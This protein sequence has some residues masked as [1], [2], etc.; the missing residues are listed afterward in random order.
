MQGCQKGMMRE[1]LHS[2]SPH[3]V[4]HVFVWAFARKNEP[5][6]AAATSFTQ[7][8]DGC[9]RATARA[10]EEG[11]I[12]FRQLTLTR[13]G[14]HYDIMANIRSLHALAISSLI[15]M[16]AARIAPFHK[17]H[18]H[19]NHAAVMVGKRQEYV[20][21]MGP[22]PSIPA[23]TTSAPN[24]LNYITPSP[25]ASP[26]AVTAQS[27]IVTSYIPQYTLCELPPIEF[28]SISPVPSAV[29]TTAPYRNY[30]ISIPEGNG[31]C[32]TIY[33]P[34]ITMVCA[35]TL[36][37]LVERWT[38]SNC[39][40]DLTFST[41]YGYVLV[42]PKEAMPGVMGT[43]A[44]VVSVN[45]SFVGSHADPRPAYSVGNVTAS[46]NITAISNATASANATASSNATATTAL[47]PRQVSNATAT[48]TPG[49]SIETLTTYFLA[50]WQQLTAGTAPSEVDLKVCRTFPLND[51][52]ECIR[53]YQVWSTSL[54]T[55]STTTVTSIN[56]STT[57]HGM[58][59][60][61]VETF[62]ANVTELLTTFSM[63]TTMALE[64]QTEWTSTHTATRTGTESGLS[65][66]M[67]PT[68]YETMTVELASGTA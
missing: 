63:S 44:P 56:I 42:T 61:L 16:T 36:T 57:I 11:R 68:V 58:S 39:A 41:D 51:S 35:T 4:S 1:L 67:A 25:G 55:M 65:T 46:S 48:I 34:T 30:S 45:T 3:F 60:V 5:R 8:H 21:T 2:S 59:Q 7:L 19:N 32:T 29:A 37:G 31:T 23:S 38:V 43:A 6:R 33:E 50:P 64:F 10:G 54:V 66:S 53:E 14:T 49:P 13:R 18:Q 12:T 27:Q 15:I 47:F 17:I 40:Q 52:T 20:P 62:V 26:V 28:F 9:L 24:V 22:P